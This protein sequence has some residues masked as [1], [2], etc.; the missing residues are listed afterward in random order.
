VEA[1]KLTRKAFDNKQ[2]KPNKTKHKKATATKC[3]NNVFMQ[4]TIEKKK[5]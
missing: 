4:T 5:K 2:T 1:N 3:S